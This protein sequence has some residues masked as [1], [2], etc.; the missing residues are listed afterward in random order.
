MSM[1][2][3]SLDEALSTNSHLSAIASG[4]GHGTVVTAYAQTAGRGQR[5]NSWESAPGENITM[6]ILLRPE[7]VQPAAQFIISEA[8]S[9][10]IVRVL[11]RYLPAVPEVAVKWPNDIYVGDGKICG[12]LIEHAI[13]GR[14]ID[15]SV[16]GIGINV[17]QSRFL[18]DAPNP[19]SMTQFTGC[20]YE[21]GMLVREFA[22]EIL[23][24]IDKA[25]L[26]Q[27]GAEVLHASYL[28]MLWRRD[29]FH[30][31]H[32][33]LTGRDIMARI[34][35]VALTGHL[36]LVTPGGESATYAFK[37]VSAIL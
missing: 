32:D 21:V 24:E 13:V 30:P 20:R 37:E 23:S 22:A 19:V 1:E 25:T 34:A 36:T 7:G 33:A 12:I 9:V 31:Y 17:N 29:G 14:R 16:A 8:V 35:D 11:R 4:C 6:S 28:S 18:S 10:G 15:Y 26:S 3:I 5:G 27:G 2:I